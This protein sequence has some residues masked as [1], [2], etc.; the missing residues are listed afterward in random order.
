V[1]PRDR[2]AIP[3][4]LRER[5]QWVVWRRESRDGHETK[6]PYRATSPQARASTTEARTWASFEP[7]ATAVERGKAD[8]LGFVF[9][10]ADPFCGVD[11][12]HC[13][14]DSGELNSTAAAIIGELDSYSE[15]SPSGGGVH[16][17]VRARLE[18][19]RRRRGP[20]EIYDRGRYFT[21][22]G[23]RLE[24]LPHSPMPRQQELDKLRALLFVSP[25][26]ELPPR[27]PGAR[28][29]PEDDRELLERAFEAR[30]GADV[31][32]LWQG[33]TLGYSSHSE[34][35]LALCAH[36]AYWTGGTP[37]GSTRSSARVA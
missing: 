14:G 37:S 5:S 12:D 18:G 6:V 3:A 10:P 23:A 31:Q 2:F 4:E 22:T 28:D 27:P 24:G 32:R 20:V 33:D 11:L 17:I 26:Q 9:T 1:N 8:G 35:D 25:A 13:R 21:M 29:A 36:L 7:A 16:V 30:N 19:G 34:V 15:W